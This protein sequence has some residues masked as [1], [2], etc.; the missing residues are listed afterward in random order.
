MDF[1][2]P[3]HILS[4]NFGISMVYYQKI[5]R[6]KETEKEST[7]EKDNRDNTDT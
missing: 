4:E 1:V 3:L 5:D 7:R 2:Q 6:E